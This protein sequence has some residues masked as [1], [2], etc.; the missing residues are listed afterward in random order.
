MRRLS[1]SLMVALG[2]FFCLVLGV[3]LITP[4]SF[5]IGFH[6]MRIDALWEA[7]SYGV[8][9]C[10]MYTHAANGYGYAAPL[11]YPDLALLPPALLRGLGLSRMVVLRIWILVL[12]LLPF[13]TT[14]GT[15]RALGMS[16]YSARILALFYGF[17][18]PQFVALF[19]T[20][21]GSANSG[22]FL[23]VFLLPILVLSTCE[24]LSPSQMW[25]IAWL[26]VTGGVGLISGHIISTV[27]A[28]LFAAL[29]VLLNVPL[30]LKQPRRVL[31][32]VGCALCVLSLSAWFWLPFIEQNLVGG[33]LIHERGISGNLL[34]TRM[35]LRDFFFPG[36]L[37]NYWNALTGSSLE[38]SPFFRRFGI[39]FFVLPWLMYCGYQW[40]RL[41]V[42]IDK[43]GKLCGGLVII[44][45]LS[46]IWA[47]VI[48]LLNHWMG[49]MQF[50]NRLYIFGTLFLGVW[51]A[52]NLER[53][54]S[55][56][57]RRGWITLYLGCSL[58]F[59]AQLPLDRG[60]YY[61]AHFHEAWTLEGVRDSIAWGQEYLP[62]KA[63]LWWT[64]DTQ[65]VCLIDGKPSADWQD[66]KSFT[67]IIPPSEEAVAVEVPKFWYKGYAA[68]LDGE[69][70]ALTADDK[71]LISILCPPVAMSRI[72]EVYYAGTLVQRVANVI[73]LGALGALGVGGVVWLLYRRRSWRIENLPQP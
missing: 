73:S 9:P 48:Q 32:L 56:L 47:P 10:R 14:Y 11:Y 37:F 12:A 13:L 33:L 4:Q 30:L 5:D 42:S 7:L 19:W 25:R 70:V 36:Y 60:L 63:A 55:L 41:W 35:T 65:P 40:K 46:V 58:L 59:F 29:I 1:F 3:L 8:F 67:V 61:R 69:D 72:L 71:G 20:Q 15:A 28:V 38:S 34:E 31:L 26:I 21:L 53:E 45:L 43:V 24:V 22:V 64:E 52:Q 50:L 66:K 68:R 39:G 17:S 2:V 6:L 62:A 57:I 18:L 44:G 16:K 49:W 54:P 27:L 51:V 23:P